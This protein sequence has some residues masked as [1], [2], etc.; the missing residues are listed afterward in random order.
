MGRP[1]VG[2]L[3][4]GL[5]VGGLLRAAEAVGGN[6]AVLVKGDPD[7]GALL[8]VLTCRGADPIVME[9]VSSPAGG[10]TWNRM[11]SSESLDSQRVARLIDG[12]KRLDRDIWAVELDVPDVEQF[13]VD[14]LAGT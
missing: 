12:K 13:I 14:S 7:A 9:R 4:S 2:R 3:P 1:E 6:G 10:F 5:V 8:V 11:K